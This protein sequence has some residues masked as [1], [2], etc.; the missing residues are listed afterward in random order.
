MG[1]G[2]LTSTSAEALSRFSSLPDSARVRLPVVCVLFGISSATVWRWVSAGRLP[3]ARRV[4][5]VTFWT[6]GELRERL[7]Q[8]PD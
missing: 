4:H 1:A 5:G 6:V 7:A 8:Q 3:P 2:K